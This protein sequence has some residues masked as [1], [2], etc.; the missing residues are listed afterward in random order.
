M[1]MNIGGNQSGTAEASHD[2][3]MD[4]FSEAIEQLRRN[5]QVKVQA[6]QNEEQ[7]IGDFVRA[8]TEAER[9]LH[10]TAQYYNGLLEKVKTKAQTK[11]NELAKHINSIR[12]QLRQQKEEYEKKLAQVTDN[13]GHDAARYEQIITKLKIE[14]SEKIKQAKAEA[15]KDCASNSQQMEV[16]RKQNAQ[17]KQQYE[18]NLKYLNEQSKQK[19]QQQAEELAKVK[20][21]L[22]RE[23]KGISQNVRAK[24]RAEELNNRLVEQCRMAKTGADTEIE[25]RTKDFAEKIARLKSEST[26]QLKSYADQS[27]MLRMQAKSTIAK[28]KKDAERQQAQYADALNKANATI[29]SLQETINRMKTVS[30]GIF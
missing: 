26:I 27:S 30:A 15:I 5:S 10:Q 20:A 4:S 1:E 8:K 13:A 9:Q 29:K 18:Q 3:C 22:E 7:L 28:L 24:S 21:E 23:K 2:F 12:Q 17:L 16:L 19:L 14:T 6:A 11:I 25:E